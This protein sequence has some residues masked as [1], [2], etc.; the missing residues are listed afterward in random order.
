MK[1][2][3]RQSRSDLIDRTERNGLLVGIRTGR[4]RRRDDDGDDDCDQQ[5]DESTQVR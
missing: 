5:V 1:E 2:R 3:R 4:R